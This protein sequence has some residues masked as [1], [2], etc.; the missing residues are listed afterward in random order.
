M[1]L[2]NTSFVSNYAGEYGAA[3][4][5]EANATGG[6]GGY[7]NFTANH[8]GIGGAA[9]AWLGVDGIRINH[10]IFINN[11][12]DQCGG[13]IYVRDDSPNCKVLNSYFKNNYVT[14]KN[15]GKGGSIDWNGKNGYIE[16]STFID[17]YAAIGGSLLIGNHNMT[18]KDSNFSFSVA[19]MRGGAIGGHH[20]SNSTIDNCIFNH[21]I[22]AG[23]TD[24]S[25]TDYGEGGA[26]H[27]HEADNI[28]ISNSKFLDV[29]AHSNGGAISLVEITNINL[30][31]LTFAG[32]VTL[33]REVLLH[34]S[35]H[36]TLQL[37]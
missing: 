3:L 23:F 17:S 20:S 13:A 32:E 29:E 31:N 37:T 8:A 5:R 4:C 33:S 7:N 36:P 26:I 30:Y 9:L 28:T 6:F 15:T 34:A 35:I 27:W 16:N 22:S 1:G 21:T 12:A 19:L 10:Y 25:L 18:L 14:D 24:S 2:I 11:T